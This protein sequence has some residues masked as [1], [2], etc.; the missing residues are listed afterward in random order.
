MTLQQRLAVFL[1]QQF[2]QI[3]VRVNIVPM[4]SGTLFALLNKGPDDNTMQLRIGG[5]SPSNGSIYWQFRVTLSRAAWPPA[6]LLNFSFY[7]S[8]EM[9]RALDAALNT[10]N[11]GQQNADYARAQQIVFDDAAVIWLATPT[12]I[13]GQGVGVAGAYVVPD[14]TLA[15]Q[16]AQIP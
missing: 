6:G 4:E 9:E 1:Q 11:P 2:A 7:N 12:N 14:Q 10:E 15:V 13:A 5:Y 16:K 8:P 3:G